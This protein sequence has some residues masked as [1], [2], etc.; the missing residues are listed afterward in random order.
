MK[1]TQLAAA[2]AFTTL[3]AA[4]GASALSLKFDGWAAGSRTATVAV[5]DPV[6]AS[7]SHNAGGFNMSET[8]T[9]NSLVAFCLDLI[10]QVYTGVTYEYTATAT[11]FSNS[12]DLVANGGMNRIQKLFDSGFDTALTSADKSAG[13]QVALWN[14]VYDDDWTVN[15]GDFTQSNAGGVKTAANEF[16]EI[17]Q[18]YTGPNVWDLTYLEGQGFNN[19]NTRSQNLVTAE[20]APVPLPAAGLMLVTALG[21][22]FAARR[23][24]AA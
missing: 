13:F 21:G 24:K 18:G 5:A 17:A 1:L 10:G 8:G 4:N 23:R 7:G 6:A 3:L 19:N 16:L 9:S 22:L 2:T 14:A 12:V 15:D 20:L 11:P